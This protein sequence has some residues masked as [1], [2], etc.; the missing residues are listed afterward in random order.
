MAYNS[1]LFWQNVLNLAAIR[2]HSLPSAF[3]LIKMQE[4]RDESFENRLVPIEL[5]FS[6]R[7]TSI[8]VGLILV[9]LQ[10]S[11]MIRGSSAGN[12][13]TKLSNAQIARQADLLNTNAV[14]GFNVNCSPPGCQ[15]AKKSAQPGFNKTPRKTLPH[16]WD[17]PKIR[18]QE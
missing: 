13:R 2:S 15:K 1:V 17:C 5:D 16:G 10:L 6:Q 12:L 8:S 9:S 4:L 7:I 14:G 11:Q 18:V 3:E